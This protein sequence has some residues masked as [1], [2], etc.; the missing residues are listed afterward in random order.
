MPSLSGATPAGGLVE[1]AH[2][3]AVVGIAQSRTDPRPSPSPTSVP[4]PPK[5]SGV[6]FHEKRKGVDAPSTKIT[7][8]VKWAAPESEGVEIRVPT[9]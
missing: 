6:S 9:A 7:Q 5:P 8:T 4:V 2:P 3:G 1:P